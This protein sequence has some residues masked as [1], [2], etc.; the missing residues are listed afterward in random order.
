[1]LSF[2]FL[3]LMPSTTPGLQ[4]AALFVPAREAPDLSCPTRLGQDP[5]YSPEVPSELESV[6]Q[7]LVALALLCATQTV[8]AQDRA[9]ASYPSKPVR[10]VILV[11]PGGGADVTSRMVGQKLTESWGQQVIVDN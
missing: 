4:A 3:L 1:M 8:V 2:S 7:F 6:M 5:A 9:S 10:I 11:Q